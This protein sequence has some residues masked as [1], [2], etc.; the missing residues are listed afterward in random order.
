MMFGGGVGPLTKM[1]MHCVCNGEVFR[2]L[3]A[4]I[5]ENYYLWN[6]CFLNVK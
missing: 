6:L 2:F 3:P 4:I 1:I 5:K